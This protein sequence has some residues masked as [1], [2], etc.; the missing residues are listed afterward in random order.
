MTAAGASNTAR[1]DSLT[2]ARFVGAFVVFI[3]HLNAEGMLNTA[4]I[5]NLG[6]A[7]VELFF[8]LSGFVLTWSA[9]AAMSYSRFLRRRLVRIFPNHVIT[10]VLVLV[11]FTC[12][13][14]NIAGVDITWG[15]GLAN[16][17]LINTWWDNIVMMVGVN[18][19]SWS[20]N[21][22]L[23]AYLLFPLLLVVGRRI[24]GHRLWWVAA[25][26]LLA[27]WMMP[28]IA[29]TLP[30][31]ALFPT[32]K[33]ARL[34][35]VWF[36]YFFPPVRLLDFSLGVLAALLVQRGRWPR[37]PVSV[38]LAFAAIWYWISLVLPGIYGM[39]AA[40]AL[41]VVLLVGALA[42]KE[43]RSGP[44]LLGTPMFRALGDASYA[45]YLL[46]LTVLIVTM[47]IVKGLWSHP[48]PLA[49]RLGLAVCS[50]LITV[51]L[52]FALHYSV[53]KPTMRRFGGRSPRIVAPIPKSE[54]LDGLQESG[55]VRPQGVV[56]GAGGHELR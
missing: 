5:R 4:G 9:P 40:M 41:P 35:D 2:G 49:A 23:I 30:G 47:K 19:P 34:T 37:L 32:L 21:L 15:S 16:L 7:A 33:G 3:C 11:I 31:T 22:D 48:L 27:I 53:E 26:V 18:G 51:V 17:L 43:L 13:G 44:G 24:P 46:H 28:T 50:L 38:A 20:L 39:D 54:G 10:F 55:P 6:F 56:G 42:D 8:V 25:G 36:V 14:L 45:F 29:S 12:F 1:L 52:S